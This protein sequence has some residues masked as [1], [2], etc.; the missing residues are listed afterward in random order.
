[1]T[2]EEIRW[3]DGAAFPM[4]GYL[5]G[6]ARNM[7]TVVITK[8][9]DQ[10]R[11]SVQGAVGRYDRDELESGEYRSSCQPAVVF[12]CDNL[13]EAQRITKEIIDKVPPIE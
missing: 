1:M 4:V 7:I 12:Y 11:V 3:S 9:D 2:T 8:D 6:T 5:F 13:G 10:L